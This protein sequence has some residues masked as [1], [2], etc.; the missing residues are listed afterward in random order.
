MTHEVS[1]VFLTDRAG[2]IV[3]AEL[4]DTIDEKNLAD[5]ETEWVP[6]LSRLLQQLEQDGIEQ[7]F[8]PQNRHWNWHNKI[9]V[10]RSSLSNQCFSI[11]CDGQTQGLMITDTVK[12]AQISTQLNQHLVYIQYLESA[13]WNR[14]NLRNSI[15]EAYSGVGSIL[16]R[17]AVDY[18]LQS[19][20][21]GRVGLHSLPQANKFY[22]NT[23]RMTDLGADENYLGL[24]Y[25]EFTP[26]QAQAFIKGGDFKR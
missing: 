26:V 4:W 7:Q 8:W 6:E 14:K 25:F 3:E 1:P 20:F 9:K 13:P 16:V 22:A 5:W 19:E 21:K 11:V 24:H 18:S 17:A 12:R 23:C 10:I 15:I 2:D